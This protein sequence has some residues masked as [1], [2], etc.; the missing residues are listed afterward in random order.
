[1]PQFFGEFMIEAGEIDSDQ[2]QA[3]LDHC[4]RVNLPVGELAKREGWL[5]DAQIREILERQHTVDRRFG[6]IAIELGYL[7]EEKLQAMVH[8]RSTSHL[9]IG[10]ALVELGHIS[11]QTLEYQLDRYKSEAAAFLREDRMPDDVARHE[12]AERSVEV[13]PRIALRMGR[14]Q[15]LSRWAASW[16]EDPRLEIRRSIE[17]DCGGTLTIGLAASRELAQQIASAMLFKDPG[18]LTP[19]ELGDALGE[20]LNLVVGSANAL[21]SNPEAPVRVS[22]PKANGF[23]AYGCALLLLTTRGPGCLVV[24]PED[25]TAS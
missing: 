6:E 3:A 21:V 1:M 8:Q 17:I 18:W 16:Q 9:Y 15:L 10:E 20:F 4:D 11:R 2:L 24:Q 19:E 5:D 14:L 25:A 12:I 23:P 7:S 13:L 22:P